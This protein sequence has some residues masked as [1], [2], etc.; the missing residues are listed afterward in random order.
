MRTL[1]II[2]YPLGEAPSQRFRF[3][4]YIGILKENNISPTFNSFIDENTWKILYTKG[5]K[6]SKISGV[7]KGFLNRILLLF[8]LHKY[9]LIF[10]H[11]EATPLGPP[12]FEWIISKIFRK[13]I[14]Y[15]FDDA[16]WLSDKHTGIH[17]WVKNTEKVNKII[18]WSYKISCGNNYLCRHS[19]HF[20]NNVV[21]NPT[22]IDT[23]YH[24]EV[25]EQSGNQLIIG[26]TGT[27]STL[28]YLNPIIPLIQR[29]SKKHNF[30]FLVICDKK[31]DFQFEGLIYRR[32]QKDTEIKDLSEMN[33]GIMPLENDLWS[34]GKCGFK[35]LQYMALGIPALAS[36]VGVNSQIID[37]GV[38]GFLC[39]SEQDWEIYLEILI[40]RT[41]KRQEMGMEAR[42]K[43]VR[44]YSVES[45]K[46]NF[47]SLFTT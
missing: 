27:H 6:F 25:K 39:E 4:Q 33:I 21:K 19:S 3:E 13:K 17:K 30:K 32:W 34:Q 26:W 2:P 43:I 8:S 9:D 36:P 20:N 1:F 14:I 46:E 5:N 10:L 12:V 24:N 38:N 23:D 7:I 47:L 44:E 16:I 15:D 22:T 28:K 45:N 18:S 40:D 35:A 11:R 41:L 29:L 37:H 42:Q 31:P